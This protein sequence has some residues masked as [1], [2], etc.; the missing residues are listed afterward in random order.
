MISTDGLTGFTIDVYTKNAEDSDKAP[1][2]AGAIASQSITL[3]AGTRTQV[4]AGA[5]LDS[6]SDGLLELVRLK[7]SVT[8][9]TN[10]GGYVHFRILNM[11]WLYN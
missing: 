1:N 7:Y 4:E 2:V 11:T 10:V 5:N 9:D 8:G 3:T 6:T